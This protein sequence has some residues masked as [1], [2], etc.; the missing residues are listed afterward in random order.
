MI[1]RRM[2]CSVHEDCQNT[3]QEADRE[4]ATL[5]LCTTGADA[6]AHSRAGDGL[7]TGSTV[8]GLFETEVCTHVSISLMRRPYNLGMRMSI[9]IPHRQTS[10]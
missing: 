2:Q 6:D 9:I 5:D 10:S 1:M 8:W 4:V 7:K 3:Y